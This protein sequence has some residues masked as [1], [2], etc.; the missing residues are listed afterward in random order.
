MKKGYLILIKHHNLIS[1]F[2]R[3]ITNSEYNHVGIFVDEENIIE[4][5][6]GGVVKTQ[7]KEFKKAKENKKLEYAIFKIKNITDDQIEIMTTF[8]KSELGARYDFAQ[9]ISIGLILLTGCTKRIEPLD[10][11][12]KWICSELIS[13]GAYFAG[14]KFYENIDPDNISPGDIAKSQIVERVV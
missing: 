10:N 4:V 5:K 8:A 1:S 14:I 11:R 2:I 13:D 6:F 12:N 7:F 9:F 3:R